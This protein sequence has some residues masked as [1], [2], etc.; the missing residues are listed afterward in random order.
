MKYLQAVYNKMSGRMKN[1]IAITIF[2]LLM[3]NRIFSQSRGNNTKFQDDR[4]V[5]QGKVADS[6]IRQLPEG[7]STVTLLISKYPLPSVNMVGV[8][9]KR[10]E[11][12]VHYNE[13]FK[14]TIHPPADR[15]Y[16]SLYYDLEPVSSHFFWSDID[17]IYILEKGDSVN[18]SLKKDFFLFSGKG[19]AKLNCESE[20]YKRNYDSSE[21]F[22]NAVNNRDYKYFFNT[23]SH[24]IDSCFKLQLAIIKQFKNEL[25]VKDQD[26]LIANSYGLR[27]YSLL[28]EI[29]QSM[30]MNGDTAIFKPVINSD[31]Y[32]QID[33]TIGKN[34]DPENLA[35]SPI[36]V[37]AIFEKIRLDNFLMVNG[38][39]QLPASIQKTFKTIK[40]QFHGSI[41]DKLLCLFF[42]N[43][44][45]TPTSFDYLEDAINICNDGIYKLYLLD[46]QER[47]SVGSLFYNFHLP[48]PSGKIINLSDFGNKV[49]IVDF[50]YTGCENCIN[51]HQA[52]K[53]VV[54]FYKDNPNFIFLS[55]SIDRDKQRWIS[56]IRSGR[57]VDPNGV[58]LFTE[59]SG[60]EHPL[61]KAAK[62][63][64]YPTTIILKSGKVV[65][66]N[67]PFPNGK[68]IFDGGTKQLINLI[69][70][71]LK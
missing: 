43:Y 46:L 19:A 13:Q 54:A 49:V 71:A 50:W 11:M 4:V 2:L 6:L 21:L 63:I 24:K 57:Y 58:N 3:C 65:S 52:M 48:D 15:F 29:R 62:I 35:Q 66:S 56:S 69:D 17:N 33:F 9:Y 42:I 8:A 55:I 39:V 18:V 1:F 20:I 45:R 16:M 38:I 26:I 41:R 28:R 53:K 7:I 51:L 22:V 64:G 61:I 5:I 70:N 23:V 31:D 59:G 44:S 47:S 10:Y 12:K 67:P 27:Y 14:L 25:S 37:S 34:V 30:G 32:K 40:N 36:Y 60:D 68:T